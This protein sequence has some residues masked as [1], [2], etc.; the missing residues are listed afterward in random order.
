MQKPTITIGI[1]AEPRTQAIIDGKVELEGYRINVVH[2]S[3]S[4]GQ[5]HHRFE[6]NEFDVCEFSTATFLRTSEASRRFLAL[7]VFFTRGPR[8]RNIYIK[9]GTLSH[10]SELKGKKIGLSRYGATANVWSRG[11]LYDEFGLKTTDMQWYVSGHELF[12]GY[13][14]PVAVERP[15]KPAQFGQDQPHL[16]KLLAQGK[17]G[18]VIIPGDTGYPAIFGGGKT[19]REMEKFPGVKSLFED[20]EEIISYVRKSRIYPIMH[21]LA[22]TETAVQRYPDLPVKLTEAFREARKVSSDYMTREEIKGYQQEQDVL[23]EDPYAY[24]LG[25]TEITSLEAL[26]R[27]QIEQGLM[28]RELDI[29]S[30]FAIG[31]I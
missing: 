6:Q 5:Q 14:L 21:T 28:K 20:T 1:A 13:D 7:P 11:L 26:N 15:E 9:Q 23:G 29:R 4:P 17:L 10:A 30:L 8:H 19:T 22:I 3:L 16:G 24:V 27:Y 31:T 25:P 12:I 2:D 18:G